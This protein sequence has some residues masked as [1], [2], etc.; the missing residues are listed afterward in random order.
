MQPKRVFFIQLFV[1]FVIS[2]ISGRDSM[3]VLYLVMKSDFINKK[4]INTK[5]FQC[6]LIVSVCGSIKNVAL[7]ESAQI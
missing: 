6:S 2:G 3:I 5:F 1:M 7:H 4:I